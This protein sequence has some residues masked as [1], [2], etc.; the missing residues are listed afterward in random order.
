MRSQRVSGFKNFVAVITQEAG[1][2]DVL[3]L[4]MVPDPASDR[5]EVLAVHAVVEPLL[6]ENHRVQ[7]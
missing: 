1:M 5:G 4:D 2:G 7:R 6:L 3:C